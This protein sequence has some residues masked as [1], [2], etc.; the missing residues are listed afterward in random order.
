MRPNLL[1]AS[2]CLLPLAGHA[3]RS[4]LYPLDWVPPVTDSFYTDKFLQDLSY[5]GYHRGDTP[6]PQVGG[7]VLDV[8]KAPYLADSSGKVEAQAA[9]QKAIDSVGKAGGG[10]VYLP[11][12]TYRLAVADAASYALKIGK[13]GVVLRGA[14]AGKTFLLNTT[15]AMRGKTVIQVSPT[16]GGSWTSVPS[17][18]TLVTRDLP[19]PTRTV[20]VENTS[21]FKVGDWVVVRQRM[22]EAWIAEHKETDWA[23]MASQFTGIAYCR[24]ILSIDAAAKTLEIDVPTRYAMLVRDTAMVYLAPAMIEET[25]VERLSMGNVQDTATTGWGEND[26]GTAGTGAYDAHD[27]WLVRFDRVR[28]GWIRGLE[29]FQPAGNTTTA[30]LLS[31]GI[32]LNQ[33][34]GVTVDSC[35]LQRPQYGGGG[36]NGYMIRVMG[37]ENLIR[38]TR[39][40]H[41][42]HG[43]VLSGMLASGN[44]FLRVHDKDAGLQTGSTQDEKTSGRGNDHHMHFSHSNLFDNCIAENSNFQAAYRPYGTAPLHDLTAAHSIYWNTEGEG[45]DPW[46][47]HTQQARYGYVVGT[48][49]TVTEVKTTEASAGSGVK[50]DPV[51]VV[52]G[53]ALGA[54]LEPASLYLDQLARRKTR[55]SVGVR[56]GRPTA[57]AADGASRF[58]GSAIQVGDHLVD[59]ARATP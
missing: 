22:S 45:T 25:G 6:L 7:L 57:S 21:L 58:T 8:T 59:G 44:V 33:T 51:D 50:T 14:G 46:V 43:F 39:S 10:V 16:A 35:H 26:Y 3:W 30:H 49:G 38:D 34:R 15:T 24:R 47:I 5:A 40:T 20:P 52:E 4:A 1:A 48:R 27:S 17:S 54:T 23:G 9:I 53:K 12:G 55:E 41:A 42:R 32:Q 29:T 28:N 2:V 11:A 31:N 18:K 19:S 13:S 37:N 36:G 56:P